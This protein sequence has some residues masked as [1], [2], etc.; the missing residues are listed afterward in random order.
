MYAIMGRMATQPC[1]PFPCRQI[2]ERYYMSL[3]GSDQRLVSLYIDLETG[4]IEGQLPP[5]LL[6]DQAKIPRKPPTIET[7][8]R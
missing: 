8:S 6:P 3:T 1:Q 4:H 7:V 2:V 5:E